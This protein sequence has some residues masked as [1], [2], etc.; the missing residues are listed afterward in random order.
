MKASNQSAF[1]CHAGEDNAFAKRLGEGLFANGVVAFV[2]DW[3]ILPGDR[4]IDKVFRE[5]IPRATVFII[6]LSK[7]SIEKPWVREELDAALVLRIEGQMKIIP[8]R[9]DGCEVPLPL[10]ATAW[11]DMQADG[12]FE[13]ELKRLLQGIYEIRQ[14]PPLG[15]PPG[16]VTHARATDLDPYE[17]AI[18]R[19]VLEKTY[20]DLGS[21]LDGK[22]ILEAVPGMSSEQ[23]N[24]AVE[25]LEGRGII[26]VTK[27]LGTAPFTF[28]LVRPT[29]HGFVGYAPKLLGIDTQK[30]CEQVIALAASWSDKG[31]ML[32]GNRI[33]DSLKIDPTRINHAVTVL[34]A[35]GLVKRW[36]GVGTA[37][38]VFHGIEANAMGRKSAR[39]R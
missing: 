1:V 32:T 2:D 5:G 9:I 33:A 34:E 15:Q 25:V 20:G 13:S 12:N 14:R 21:Y 24:D 28:G 3:E 35:K 39:I 23:V 22:E 10:K 30:D 29:S 7:N 16:F 26:E 18:L 11:I 4:L 6:I 19:L 27:L 31:Q 38:Y 8:V 17:E 37:P 36:K